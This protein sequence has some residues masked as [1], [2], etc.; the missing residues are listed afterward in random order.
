MWPSFLNDLRDT[1][2]ITSREKLTITKKN[3]FSTRRTSIAIKTAFDAMYYLS[4]SWII[5]REP[6]KLGWE[7]GFLGIAINDGSATFYNMSTFWHTRL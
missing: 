5:I 1:V 7:I 4:D 3:V 6:V 2:K